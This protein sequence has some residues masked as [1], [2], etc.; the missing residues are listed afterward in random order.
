VH[1]GL[2]EG[3]LDTRL[4]ETPENR[5]SQIVLRPPPDIDAF[6]QANKRESSELSPNPVNSAW[7]FGTFCT[8][9]TSAAAASS[10]RR[11]RAG[12]LP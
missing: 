4:V 11:T 7:G 10:R 5:H 2:R 12:S 9:G 6:D 3:D 1:V 8:S